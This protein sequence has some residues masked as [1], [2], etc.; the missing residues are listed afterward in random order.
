LCRTD[1][2]GPGLALFFNYHRHII[3]WS[4]LIAIAWLATAK[5]LDNEDLL[6]IGTMEAST[7]QQLCSVIKWGH[8][9][10][11]ST[12]GVKVLFIFVAYVGT[13]GGSLVHAVLQRRRFQAMDDATTMRDFAALC[14]GIP[15]K[16]N[17]DDAEKELAEFLQG[18]TG[19]KVVGAVIAWSYNNQ[20]GRVQE[21]CDR[22]VA[23]AHL[24]RHDTFVNATMRDDGSTREDGYITKMF[25]N[26]DALL[27]FGAP[28]ESSAEDSEPPWQFL[29]DMLTGSQLLASTT[30]STAAANRAPATSPRGE[31]RGP[32]RERTSR[33]R[34][35]G[36]LQKISG[37]GGAHDTSEE[38][39][40]EGTEA[41]GTSMFRHDE[42][43]MLRNL[44]TSGD[45]IIVFE[46][47]QSRDSAVEKVN[48]QHGVMLNTESGESCLMLS[49]VECEPDTVLWEN[50]AWPTGFRHV[51]FRLVL[52]IL[53]I[54]G[55]VTVWATCFY[56][57]YA[58]YTL[59]FS[60][61][62]GEM[63]GFFA[64]TLFTMLVVAG[65]Q[66]MYFLCSFVTYHIRFRCQDTF[67]FT[68]MVLYTFACFVNLIFD[69]VVTFHTTYVT[70]V[71]MDVRTF[72]GK[73]LDTL[74]MFELFMS[75][76]MQRALG[77]QMFWYAFPSCFL[78]PYILEPI[79]TIYV[80]LHI[81]K[82]IV[83]SNKEFRGYAAEQALEYFCPMDLSRYAD[84]MLNVCIAVSIL[85]FPGG[86]V[87]QTF[88]ILC[89]SH[90]YMYAYDHYR[91]LR[92]IPGLNL[93]SEIV[94]QSV[95]MLTAMP[96]C[97]L[98]ACLIFK[99]H[100][101]PGWEDVSKVSVLGQIWGACMM[102][103]I[104][105]IMVLLFVVP[106][107]GREHKRSK[108]S[109]AEAASRLPCSWFNANPVH[110]LRTKYIFNHKPSVVLYVR[111]KEHLQTAIP[112]LGVHFQG[113]HV[114]S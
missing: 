49:S 98:L 17:S 56:L 95:N 36:P 86:Y 29:T 50:C 94:D 57:P 66:I 51:F 5:I 97:I 38:S 112:S 77:N 54:I 92:E 52:G 87:L 89:F 65:N 18:A 42:A 41:V 105:H 3:I 12:M 71:V 83:R 78:I 88:G 63:P 10:M 9:Y 55:A 43:R 99:I 46:S 58:Y 16:F 110:C 85:L 27:G 82:L 24:R 108:S 22:E 53:F 80:P 19:E 61:A 93:G 76:P 102:H 103:I 39:N 67:E 70:M 14:T 44:K 11:S 100:C 109:Y 91:V 34:S 2:A 40:F 15:S 23:V 45:A 79:F 20:V 31:T 101:L 81:A 84:I 73:T 35:P 69:L 48:E 68:Y 114:K 13:F 74:S 59:S 1:V 62:R 47:E 106:C 25:K 8:E 60:Y 75:Y 90:I 107:F 32:S 104:V 72:D 21:L 37:R 7:P 26:V 4:F 30:Q 64:T 111:G 6:V 113:Y 96:C 28:G 33:E